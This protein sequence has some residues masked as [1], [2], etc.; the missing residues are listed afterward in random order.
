MTPTVQ[1]REN[2]RRL[3][4]DARIYC[5]RLVESGWEVS[6]QRLDLYVGRD[7]YLQAKQRDPLCACEA[8]ETELDEALRQIEMARATRLGRIRSVVEQLIIDDELVIPIEIEWS[9]F[10]PPTEDDPLEDF[11]AHTELWTSLNEAL[12]LRCSAISGDESSD[13]EVWKWQRVQSALKDL[14]KAVKEAILSC[15]GDGSERTAGQMLYLYVEAR[16]IQ[17]VIDRQL[18]WLYIEGKI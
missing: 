15:R 16:K 2:L 17:P 3:L 14:G 4:L 12:P 5:A 6:E 7:L 11:P 1:Q 8:E 13:F 10:G 9:F 18:K